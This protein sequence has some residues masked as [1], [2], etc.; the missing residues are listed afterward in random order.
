[1]MGLNDP[2]IWY[3]RQM[4]TQLR[5]VTLQIVNATESALGLA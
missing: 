3:P 5:R 1:M 4:T 2:R